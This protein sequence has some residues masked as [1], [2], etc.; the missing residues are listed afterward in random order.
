MLRDKLQE[1]VALLLGFYVQM[2]KG[3]IPKL[4]VW[5]HSNLQ[6]MGLILK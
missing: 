3:P 1:N 2:K 6:K 5:A 4:S